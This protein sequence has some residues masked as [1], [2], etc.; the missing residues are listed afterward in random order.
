MNTNL[1]KKRK[2]SFLSVLL[3][4]AVVLGLVPFA[5]KNVYAGE[6]ANNRFAYY[7]SEGLLNESNQS[8]EG[9]TP[10]ETTGVSGGKIEKVFTDGDKYKSELPPYSV[11]VM[12]GNDTKNFK[13]MKVHSL[14]KTTASNQ[15]FLASYYAKQMGKEASVIL[16]YG[17]YL[18]SSL[19][20]NEIGS[21][22]LLEWNNLSYKTPGAIYAVCYNQKDGAYLLSGTVNKNGTAKF[23]DYILRDGTSV[24]IFAVK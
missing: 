19:P 2:R 6:A 22:K 20:T 13:D 14:D 9:F 23:N 4:L 10:P 1:I 24:T 16:S 21:K 11:I 5:V 12:N 7:A 18:R 8:Q 17:V 3:A 15:K